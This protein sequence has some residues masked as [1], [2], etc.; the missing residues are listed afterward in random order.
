MTAADAVAHLTP[1]LWERANRLLVRKA[2]SEFAHERLLTPEPLDEAGSYRVLSDDGTVEY[3]FTAELRALDHWDISEESVVR[4]VRGEL[5]PPDAVDL[6]IELRTA[7]GLSDDVL[8]VYLEEIASTLAGTAYKL[9]L[10]PVSSAEL[11]RAGFQAVETGMTEGHP[12]F[13]AN[14]GRLGFGVHEYLSYAPEAASPVRL[15]WLAAHRERTTFTSCADLD[16]DTLVREELGEETLARFAALLT[17]QGLDPDDYYLLPVHPWQWWNKL[18]VTFAAEV[19]ERRLVCLGPGDDEY[20]AQQSIRTFFNTTT[21]HKHYVKTALSVLNMGFMRGLSAAYMEATPA[22]NDWL[23]GLIEQDPVLKETGFSIIREHAAIGYRHRQYELATDRYSPYRKM[24][25]A[26]WRESPVPSLGPGESLATMASLLHIDRDGASFAGALIDASGQTPADWLRDYLR[27]YLVPVLHS[28]YAYDLAYMPHGEN[29]ILVLGAD[30]TVRR[31][32]FKDI[33]EEIVVM[34]PD[35]I[36]PPAVERVR[37]EVPEDMK[38]LS[39]FTDVFDCFFR[40]LSA[41]LA[42][43]GRI[44]EDAFWAAVADCARE[45]QASVPHLADR[46]AEYDLF[47]PEFAL[48]CLNRLQLRNNRQMVDLAD[49]SAALQLVGTLRNPLAAV[50]AAAAAP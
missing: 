2:L 25:A 23:A 40:F 28:F 6:C 24:L 50:P 42:A 35:A 43:E 1:E 31:A 33:A 17:G 41:A 38:L 34:D 47:A 32:I 3:R 21:P 8:P 26:L 45:Y 36:L 10:E 29:V 39:V 9:S 22:I 48:S 12:C 4:S 5:L 14:N 13:V 27:A 37:A 19:A 30:G 49:P 11:V 46:F 7:L 44:D 20:L 16:Y 18:S 15:I